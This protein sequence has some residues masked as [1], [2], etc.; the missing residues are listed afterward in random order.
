MLNLERVSRV[1]LYTLSRFSTKVPGSAESQGEQHITP[2]AN[3]RTSHFEV[4]KIVYLKTTKLHWSRNCRLHCSCTI[5][6]TMKKL[7][8]RAPATIVE[9]DRV[10]YYPAIYTGAGMASQ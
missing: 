3:Q 1:A 4:P 10:C 6:R 2:G 8:K 5:P 7:K 9:T